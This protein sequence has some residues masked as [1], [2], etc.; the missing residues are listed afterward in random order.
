[1]HAGA[2]N[3]VLVALQRQ[4]ASLE[5][6]INGYCDNIRHISADINAGRHRPDASLSPQPAE[7]SQLES[8]IQQER[9]T[10]IQLQ[11]DMQQHKRTT[12]ERY[13]TIM[14]G[15]EAG[16]HKCL[17]LDGQLAQLRAQLS[18]Q[19]SCNV[20]IQINRDAAKSRLAAVELQRE[21]WRVAAIDRVRQLEYR[22]VELTASRGDLEELSRSLQNTL[23]Q[24]QHA[25]EQAEAGL[26]KARD[27][28]EKALVLNQQLVAKLKRLKE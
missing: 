11:S 5:D 28:L 20:E 27:M 2:V 12:D 25:R 14:H 8:A 7:L 26:D 1:M 10:L 16:R 18:H 4:T 3:D 19:S 22:H 21:G 23:Q 13:S 15:K 17:T 24:S 9:A 6:Q